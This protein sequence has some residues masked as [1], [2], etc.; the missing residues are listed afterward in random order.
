MKHESVY[1]NILNFYSVYAIS[2][3]QDYPEI[4]TISNWLLSKFYEASVRISQEDRTHSD[5]K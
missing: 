4:V 1:K 5:T 3:T 2:P